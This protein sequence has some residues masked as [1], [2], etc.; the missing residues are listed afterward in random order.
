MK[1]AITALFLA[2][3]LATSGSVMV[4]ADYCEDCPEAVAPRFI[5]RPTDCRK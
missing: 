5:Y 1:K 2:L 4:F 3:V